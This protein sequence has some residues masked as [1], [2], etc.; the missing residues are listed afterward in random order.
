MTRTQTIIIKVIIQNDGHKL[1]TRTRQTPRKARSRP[2]TANNVRPRT[3]NSQSNST[4]YTKH[5][6][7]HH[8][9]SQQRK[10]RR[11]QHAHP[12]HSCRC[13]NNSVDEQWKRHCQHK[14]NQQLKRDAKF[15][16][17][18]DK[19]GR[20]AKHPRE[21]SVADFPHF[22]PANAFTYAPNWRGILPINGRRHNKPNT[23]Q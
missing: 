16:N 5:G 1:K 9:R 11:P 21:P 17:K 14:R 6:K 10:H 2:R 13:N 12:K 19:Y 4:G 7:H 18:F 22:H 3:R 8:R 20:T 15:R 23:N